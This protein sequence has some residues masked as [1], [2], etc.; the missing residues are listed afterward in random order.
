MFSTLLIIIVPLLRRSLLVA[1]ALDFLAIFG[2]FTT[3]YLLG[4]AAPEMMGVYMQRTFLEVRDPTRAQTQAVISF[5]ICALVGAIYVHGAGA[6]AR[7]MSGAVRSARVDVTGI[8]LAVLLTVLIAGPLLSVLLW[9]FAE[10]WRYPSLIPAQWP[11]RFW[12]ATLARADVWNAMRLSLAVAVTTLSALICLPAAYAFARLRFPGRQ[13]LLMSFLVT[14]AFPKLSL[15]VAIAAIFLRL[16]LVGTFQGVVLIQL[17]NTLLFMIWIPVGAFQGVDRRLE[18]A[19]RAVGASAVQVF[20]H[21]TLPQ[22]RPAIA[23]AVMLTL[24]GTFYETEGAWLIGAPN[25]RSMP[26]LM[27]SMINNQL[28]VQYGA[29]LSVLLW[30]P[31]FVVML[32]AR[33]ILS[34]RSMAAEFGA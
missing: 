25:I 17:L 7:H 12:F 15:Y 3:P 13:G 29:V 30:A 5:L 22:A 16:D 24:I 23:A 34:A 1:F 32:F 27:I 33:R 6:A 8:G 10:V 11:L 26:I 9:V 18:E 14:Q 4:P 31:S 28:I 2:S 19:A 20:W 21:I